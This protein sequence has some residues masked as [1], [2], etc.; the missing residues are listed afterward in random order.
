MRATMTTFIV[1]SL[2]LGIQCERMPRGAVRPRAYALHG[3]VST[4]RGYRAGM[5]TETTVVLVEGESDRRALV[6]VARRLERDLAAAGVDIVVMD[7]IT[8]LRRH[9]GRLGVDS[10][11]F[12]V[13]GLFDVGE[14]ATVARMLTE[15]G[16]PSAGSTAGLE[17][18]GFF[19]CSLDLEDELIR[20]AGATLVQDVIASRGDLARLRSFQRQPAQRERAIGAQLRRFAGTASG[21]KTWF[22]A[23]IVE[24]LPLDRVPG[25]LA[26]LL[27]AADAGDRAR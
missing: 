14:A 3:V 8:N 2:R 12:R 26:R 10:P 19:A 23:D 7:G 11:E 13:L 18:L 25:P 22:A 6:A 24:V 15:A 17:A 20:A 9:L 5:R 4:V 1:L 21:R 27:D 16:H